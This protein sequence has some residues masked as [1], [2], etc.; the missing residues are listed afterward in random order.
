MRLHLRG[1]KHDIRRSRTV[2]MFIW[3]PTPLSAASA[4]STCPLPRAT[5]L[6]SMLPTDRTRAPLTGGCVCS[7]TLIAWWPA[8]ST[9]V[10]SG[11]PGF[12]DWQP[13]EEPRS[14]CPPQCRSSSGSG[15]PGIESSERRNAVPADGHPPFKTCR[16][17]APWAGA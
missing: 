2:I 3:L 12:V 6:R 5:C 4:P 17:E 10:P 11:P 14:L 8:D 13:G 16:R 7:P 15:E 1:Q 9:R